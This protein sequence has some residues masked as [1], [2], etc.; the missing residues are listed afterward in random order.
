MYQNRFVSEGRGPAGHLTWRIF[1]F[2][3]L[4]ARKLALER[5]REETSTTSDPSPSRKRKITDED[6]V[7]IDVDQEYD[8]DEAED[9]KVPSSSTDQQ[10][11]HQKDSE[12][13]GICMRVEETVLPALEPL[14]HPIRCGSDF[15]YKYCEKAATVALNYRGS[16]S[17]LLLDESRV[18]A[19]L[20]SP[21][22]QSFRHPSATR[23]QLRSI[24]ADHDSLMKR[25]TTKMTTA[26]MRA[27]MGIAGPAW[28]SWSS[29][30]SPS[31]MH[32]IRMA[33]DRVTVG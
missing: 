31:Y 7:D 19:I 6:K 33:F 28:S 16:E 21:A 27:K 24:E 22:Q 32:R 25:T 10:V 30:A 13:D 26:T 9:E 17:I 18:V 2:D 12:I 11:P 14:E 23:S 29:E 3:P 5:S 8:E 20:V 4:R 1:D 15:P